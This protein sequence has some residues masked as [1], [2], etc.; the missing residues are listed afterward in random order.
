MRL[1][2]RATA[3]YALDPRTHRLALSIITSAIPNNHVI[4]NFTVYAL[5]HK[6]TLVC[7]VP[8]K[9]TAKDTNLQLSDTSTAKLATTMEEMIK[10]SVVRGYCVYKKVIH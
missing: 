6:L 3:A 9:Y 8:G 10:V 2:G 1:Y 5:M 7:V 4:L